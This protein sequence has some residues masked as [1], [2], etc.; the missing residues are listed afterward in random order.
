M[1]RKQKICPHGNL[2][3]WIQ[4]CK[5]I[6]HSNGS[7]SI[8]LNNLISIINIMTTKW[9]TLKKN[10]F[11]LPLLVCSS[12]ELSTWITSTFELDVDGPAEHDSAIFY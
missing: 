3:G 10:T 5:H 7:E 9:T 6:G 12:S 8:E 11:N 1:Q 2:T 4:F